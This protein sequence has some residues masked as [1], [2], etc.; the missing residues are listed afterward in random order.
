MKQDA[1]QER[2]EEKERAQTFSVFLLETSVTAASLMSTYKG[3]IKKCHCRFRNFQRAHLS[4]HGLTFISKA[5]NVEGFF[6]VVFLILTLIKS[7]KLSGL[8]RRLWSLS[9]L[10]YQSNSA[11]ISEITPISLLSH[12]RCDYRDKKTHSKLGPALDE[13][14][15]REAGRG[16][17]C[18]VYH[19]F[20]RHCYVPD[21]LVFS[22]LA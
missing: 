9:H 8:S 10:N 11:Q 4:C 14:F 7:C 5:V 22:S 21:S 3:F 20:G 16:G 15:A 12:H 17:G 2:W 1:G 13:R 19:N 18:P 6:V